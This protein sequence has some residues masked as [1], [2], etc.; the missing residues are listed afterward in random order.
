MTEWR[1]PGDE[2]IRI[3]FLAT[4][5]KLARDRGLTSEELERLIAAQDQPDYGSH[6]RAFGRAVKKLREEQHMSRKTLAVSA[7]V[8]VRL[9][10]QI[11]RGHRGHASVPEV[12]RIAHALKLMPQELMAHYEQAFQHANWNA[13]TE[14]S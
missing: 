12:C 14:S 6:E 9:L 5:T 2:V 7:G 10:I 11:E 8:P 13:N 3:A 4:V 1:Y